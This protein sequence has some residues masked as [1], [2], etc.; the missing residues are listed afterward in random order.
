MGPTIYYPDG[1]TRQG[2]LAFL[3]GLALGGLVLAPIAAAAQ[4][5]PQVVYVV[6]VA[7][8]PVQYAPVGGAPAL[9]YH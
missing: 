5:P 8:A 1:T 3:G 6:P 9:T 2:G 7:Q 4:R